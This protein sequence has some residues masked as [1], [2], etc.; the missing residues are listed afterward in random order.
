MIQ[1]LL[2]PHQMKRR[3]I[4]PYKIHKDGREVCRK[5]P[6][7]RKEYRRRVLVAW[8]RDKHICGWCLF[9]VSEEEVTGDHIVSRGHG[10]SKRD[11]REKN[12][13][14]AHLFCNSERSSSPI[15]TRSE[16]LAWKA[17]RCQKSQIAA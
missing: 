1:P 2:K 13:R 11:D 4:L 15:L 17:N 14:P 12:L 10:G 6:A 9:T 16:W 8:E 5:T 7:G 3:Q